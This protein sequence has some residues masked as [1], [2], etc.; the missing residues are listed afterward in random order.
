M[1]ILL[2]LTFVFSIGVFADHHEESKNKYE[3]EAN[4]AEYYV[5]TFNKGKDMDDLVDWYEDMAE[6]MEEKG[7]TTKK[8]G[9]LQSGS[10]TF[11]QIWQRRIL[12]GK[13]HGL[14]LQRNL[15]D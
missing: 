3:Q 4:K 14:T 6:W 9:R 7:D 12:C 10:Q 8:R 2:T 1:R 13:T 5:G 15:L 11:P